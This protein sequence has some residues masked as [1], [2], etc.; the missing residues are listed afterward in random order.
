MWFPEKIGI[1]ITLAVFLGVSFTAV[2]AGNPPSPTLQVAVGDH[3]ISPTSNFDTIISVGIPSQ[4]PAGASNLYETSQF[5]VLQSVSVSDARPDGV[6]DPSTTLVSCVVT[7]MNVRNVHVDCSASLFSWR[8][9]PVVYPGTSTGIYYVGFGVPGPE[10]G[11]WTFTYVV[12]GLY[13]GQTITLTK[14]FNVNVDPPA[15]SGPVVYS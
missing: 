6:V 7:S 1:V 10:T 8:V 2:T 4:Q 12:T 11:V 3:R 14:S 5:F 15:A 13:N 9:N